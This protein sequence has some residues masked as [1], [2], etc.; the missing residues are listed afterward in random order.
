MRGFFLEILTFSFNHIHTKFKE[1]EVVPEWFL[2]GFYGSPNTSKR[3]ES[4]KLLTRLNP[5]PERH[6]R[7]LGNFNEITTQEEKMGGRAQAQK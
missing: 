1:F 5:S 6:W 2:S 7:I 4:W 3:R